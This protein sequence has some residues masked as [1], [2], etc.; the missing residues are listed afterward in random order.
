MNLLRKQRNKKYTPSIVNS[1]AKLF[2]LMQKLNIPWY[3]SSNLDSEV[4]F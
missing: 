2:K 3:C 1:L 4:T